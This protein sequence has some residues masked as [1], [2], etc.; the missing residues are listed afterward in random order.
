MPLRF[1][2]LSHGE[3]PPGIYAVVSDF[4]ENYTHLHKIEHQ[5]K[6]YC[7]VQTT[8]YLMVARVRVDD[9]NNTP[10]E[11][12]EKLHEMFD[13][14]GPPH[15]VT[16]THCVISEDLVHDHAAVQ[17]YQTLLIKHMQGC[18]ADGVVF[19]EQHQFSGA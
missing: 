4:S 12:K 14:E 18:A 19:K 2:V 8:L 17:H 11:E 15:V 7:Q 16:E 10:P 13:K 9:L 6:Y 1:H 5:S 3:P